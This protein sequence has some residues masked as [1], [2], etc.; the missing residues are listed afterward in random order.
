MTVLSM[1]GKV[2]ARTDTL[3]RIIEGRLS[4]TQ[5]VQILGLSRRQVHRILNAYRRNG[6]AGLVSKRRGSRSNRWFLTY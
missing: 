4:C 6:P 2:I 1:R 5:A 3:E